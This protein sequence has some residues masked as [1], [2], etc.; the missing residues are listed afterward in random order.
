MAYEPLPGPVRCLG[1][2]CDRTFRSVDKRTNRICPACTK[3]MGREGESR[4]V[5]RPVYVKGRRFAPP[6]D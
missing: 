4:V 3:K 1:P 2:G 5:P 6:E